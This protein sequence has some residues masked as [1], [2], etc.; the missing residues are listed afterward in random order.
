MILVKLASVE[1]SHLFILSQH[2]LDQLSFELSNIHLLLDLKDF[3]FFHGLLRML[4]E[5]IVAHTL[6]DG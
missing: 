1:Y 5:I 2:L 6:L 4:L 3:L